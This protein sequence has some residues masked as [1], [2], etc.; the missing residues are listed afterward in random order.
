MLLVSPPHLGDQ[1]LRREM[2]QV[3]V[4][5]RGGLVWT[6]RCYGRMEL[7]AWTVQF[8]LLLDMWVVAVAKLCKL[9]MGRN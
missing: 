9:Y 3:C 2:A 4:K 8:Q 7:G 1:A 5:G 6:P